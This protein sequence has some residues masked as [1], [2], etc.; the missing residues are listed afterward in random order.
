MNGRFV[1]SVCSASEGTSEE[2][3]LLLIQIDGLPRR[4]LEAAIAAGRMPFRAQVARQRPI[5]TVTRFTRAFQARPQPCKVSY[6]TALKA[7]FPP[8]VFSTDLLASWACCSIPI[9]H[10]ASKKNSLRREKDFSKA[11]V[12]GRIFSPVGPRPRRVTSAS[13]GQASETPGA[14]PRSSQYLFFLLLQLPAMLRISGL[15]LLELVIGL[16]EAA[17]RHFERTVVFPRAR[18]GVIANVRRSS[19]A[20]DR[21]HRRKSGCH[22]RAA[23]RAPQLPRL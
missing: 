6:T 12:P 22:P 8:L 18:H 7:A 1:I 14:R 15:V 5:S 11:A 13:R 4:Q 3:G 20:G 2:P 17:T 23:G 9:G 16:P 21:Y 10:D 19:P